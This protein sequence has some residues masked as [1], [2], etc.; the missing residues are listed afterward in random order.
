VKWKRIDKKVWVKID[1]L[2][3]YEYMIEEYRMKQLNE[4]SENE[5]TNNYKI[6]EQ[7]IVENFE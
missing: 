2:K 6:Y 1:Q 4:N 7:N 3:N 5:K